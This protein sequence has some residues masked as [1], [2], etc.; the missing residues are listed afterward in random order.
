MAYLI[1]GTKTK[2][3]PSIP[4]AD[5]GIFAGGGG[6]L[7]RLLENSSDNIFFLFFYSSTYL[8]F[9]RGYP[10]VISKKTII[11]QGFR[12]GGGGG[13]GSNIFRGWRSKCYTFLEKP[14]KYVI[15]SGSS[16]A[17]IPPL[18]PPMYLIALNFGLGPSNWRKCPQTQWLLTK[19]LHFML[20]FEF[21]QF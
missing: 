16:G 7:S 4:F 15:F 11:F 18:D 17:T 6:V 10:M 2:Q 21:C 3:G 9:Y 20:N 8:K 14:I 1:T 5:P 19:C 13:G 12:V